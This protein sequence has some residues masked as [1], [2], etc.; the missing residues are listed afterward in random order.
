MI[1]NVVVEIS[2]YRFG[3]FGVLMGVMNLGL[4]N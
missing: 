3:D 4:G 1:Y 2:I